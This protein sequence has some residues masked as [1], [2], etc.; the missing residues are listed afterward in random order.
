MNP[1]DPSP[2]PDTRRLPTRKLIGL[3]LVAAGTVAALMFSL[4][5]RFVFGGGLTL[6]PGDVALRDIRAPAHVAYVSGIETQ[7][8]RDLAEASVAPIFTAPDAQVSRQQLATARGALDQIAL[9]RAKPGEL[10]ERI[11]DLRQISALALSEPAAR[12]ILGYS[13]SEWARV[14]VQIMSAL[15]G[16]LRAPVRPDNIDQTRRS[17]RLMISLSLSKDQAEL[18]E[19]IAGV[20]LVPNTNFDDQATEAARKNAR[21]GVKPVQRVFE[22]NQIVLRSGQ[23]VGPPDI[24][25]LD[26]LNLRRPALTPFDL[27]GAALLSLMSVALL[28]LTLLARPDRLRSLPVRNVALS[29]FA[30]AASVLLARWLLP[31]HG[32][33]PFIAPVAAVGI[34]ITAWSGSLTGM[35]G[36][37][38]AGL[39]IALAMDRPLEFAAMTV[40]GGVTGS[41]ILGRANRLSDFIR[42][43][44]LA[45]LAQAVV[46]LAF[47]ITLTQSAGDMPALASAL[48]SSMVSGVVSAGL[49]LGALYL[50]SLL[51]DITTVVQ[52]IDLAR[53]SHTLIQKLLLQAPGTYHHSLMVGNLAEQ[54]AERIGAD[55]LLVRTGAYYHDIGKIE[56]PH[57]FIENQMEGVNIHDT[58]DPRTSAS[59][60]HSHVTNGMALAARHHL[61]SR[62]RSFI[63]E[64]HGT[65]RTGFQVPSRGRGRG[66]EA[67]G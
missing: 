50:S 5:L 30:L 28:T 57:H 8:Q 22:E 54:A 56:A 66:R 15:D 52:L 35:I 9:L 2:P 24:E 63:A 51:F 21:D 40:F 1:D 55:S 39:L 20:M 60:L 26:M 18:A 23:I 13:D 58:L 14:D 49:A 47:N 10:Q 64:H 16:A 17:L 7:R 34:A 4:L 62:I 65:G 46:I 41:L 61:P 43:G 32:L 67:G 11:N 44:V 38:I 37:V 27:A 45:G 36:V 31:G 29:A 33:L 42:A 12:A 48:V 59:L 53:P 25:S 19:Q 6:A 3:G